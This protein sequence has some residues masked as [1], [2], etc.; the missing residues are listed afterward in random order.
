MP[1]RSLACSRCSLVVRVSSAPLLRRN[2]RDANLPRSAAQR[3]SPSFVPPSC[4]RTKGQGFKQ[5]INLEE[6][7]KIKC[8]LDNPKTR[9]MKPYN[10]YE[11]YKFATT[12]KEFY[13]K[14]GFLRI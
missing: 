3:L 13:E 6:S 9:G 1:G 10:R 12:V 7:Q 11:K 8:L 2:A 5:A 4:Q 14:G